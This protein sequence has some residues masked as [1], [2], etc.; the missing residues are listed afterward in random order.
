MELTYYDIRPNPELDAG[1]QRQR[2]KT[3][4][5][6]TASNASSSRQLGPREIKRRPLPPGPTYSA[7]AELPQPLRIQRQLPPQPGATQSMTPHQP[8]PIET[9]SCASS[10]QQQWTPPWDPNDYAFDHNS[11]PH[12]PYFGESEHFQSQDVV[13][14]QSTNDRYQSNDYPDSPQSYAI[15][16]RPIM[17][18]SYSEPQP[19]RHH[20]SSPVSSPY[21][22]GSSP[23]APYNSSPPVHQSPPALPEIPPRTN[24]ISTSP[25]KYASY[26]D[27]PRRESVA[28]HDVPQL[29]TA[30]GDA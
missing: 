30:Y 23:V 7:P 20:H 15:D 4:G 24:R 12:N 14:P 10:P 11:S 27:G 1:K 18:H 22:P 9:N 6:D 2:E 5:S 16:P 3:Y 26:R 29:W 17:P 13:G 25:T 28:Q 19:A 21:Q 8:H